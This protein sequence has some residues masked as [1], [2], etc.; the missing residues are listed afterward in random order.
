MMNPQEW[1]SRVVT[2]ERLSTESKVYAVEIFCCISDDGQVNL[3]AK[4]GQKKGNKQLRDLG[5]LDGEAIG[6]N[7][8]CE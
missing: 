3:D 5:Y 4:N 8:R 6:I 1:L 7:P 2:D